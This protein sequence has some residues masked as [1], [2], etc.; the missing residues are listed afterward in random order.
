MSIFASRTA[1]ISLSLYM[2]WLTGEE[3]IVS[4]I[5]VKMPCHIFNNLAALLSG[6]LAEKIWQGN[7]SCDTIYGEFNWKLHSKLMASF[8]IKVNS[9]TL[10][11][12]QVK[13]TMCDAIYIGNTQQKPKTIMNGHF[14]DVQFIPKIIHKT[15]F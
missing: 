15:D 2:R 14:Y 10:F 8:S 12:I 9:R 13:Y 7:L 3:N 11:N 6:D 4:C 1:I 5:R